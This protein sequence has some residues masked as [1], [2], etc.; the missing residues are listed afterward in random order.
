MTSRE[1]MRALYAGEPVDK[2]PNGLGAC[3]TAGMHMLTY[4]RLKEVLGVS[5]PTS[6][7]CTFMCNAIFEPSVI[8]A[9]DG[10]MILLNSQMCSA[11]FRGP[12]AEGRWKDQAL[13]GTTVQVPNEWNFRTEPDG[14]VWWEPHSMVCPPGGF[15]FDWPPD[16][17]S[18]TE[19]PDLDNQPS[20]DDFN[21]SMDVP[22]ERLREMEEIAKWLYETTD[23]SIVIGESISDLQSKPGGLQAWWMRMVAEPNACHAFLDKM[24]E[25][26]LSQL[27]QIHDAV[28]KY[29]DAM[30]IADDIGDTRG[31]TCG[32]DLWRDIY[33]PHYSRLWTEWKTITPIKSMLHCCG[34]VVDIL[35]DFAEGGLGIFNPIQVSANNMAPEDL[36]ER[37][38][39]DLIFYG[40]ALDAV[41]TP[42]WKSADEVYEQAKRVIKAFSSKGRYIFA[43]THNLPPETPAAHL[44]AILRAYNELKDHPQ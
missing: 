36:A 11:P 4:E 9:M 41:V 26:S 24:V 18:H 10:D 14:T 8:D 42:A 33:K 3:E 12:L 39:A 37:F 19:L 2:I 30:I 32:P 25:A 17:D 27:R 13:W 22:E 6:R 38:G 29:C 21:P 28:G 43:G 20:P 15:Y 16:R 5:D 7:M 44:E 31:V 35:G 34:S 40:G 23:Y 1:R